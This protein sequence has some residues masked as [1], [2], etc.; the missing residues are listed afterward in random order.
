MYKCILRCFTS[1]LASSQTVNNDSDEKPVPSTEPD[2]SS[3]DMPSPQNQRYHLICNVAI[4]SPGRYKIIYKVYKGAMKIAQRSF[5][6]A[7]HII[8]H[9]N[10]KFNKNSVMID[11]VFL[12]CIL[13]G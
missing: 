8:E 10:T 11:Y 3:G 6:S 12:L 9:N 7:L 1:S 4:M 5:D 2:E 13:I